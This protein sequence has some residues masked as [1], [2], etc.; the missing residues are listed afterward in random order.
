[1]L[2]AAVSACDDIRV[3]EVSPHRQIAPRAIL[4]Q[5]T[6]GLLADP[7]NE[8]GAFPIPH[9]PPHPE[10]RF[11]PVDSITVVNSLCHDTMPISHATLA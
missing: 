10:A 2:E 5:P 4:R 6:P 11:I 3:V 8:E 7:L 9:D 1:M